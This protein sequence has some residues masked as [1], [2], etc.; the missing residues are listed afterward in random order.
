[1]ARKTQRPPLVLIQDQRSIGYSGGFRTLIPIHFVH[2]FRGFRTA[3]K[4]I[5]H[6]GVTSVK[7]GKPSWTSTV[8][9]RRNMCLVPILLCARFV[10][11]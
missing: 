5:F 10:R 1:M 6:A 9:S 2:R 7:W 11:L 8:R 4:R 3:E